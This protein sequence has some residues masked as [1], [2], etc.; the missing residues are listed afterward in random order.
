MQLSEAIRLGAMLK[1]QGFDAWTPGHS[2]ALQAAADA[3]GIGQ[4]DN[5]MYVEA[6]RRWPFL[7]EMQTCPACNGPEDALVTLW[8]LNDQH[9]WTRERIADWVATIEPPVTEPV[10]EALSETRG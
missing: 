6:R 10:A 4:E 1:P 3:V 9:H 5:L 2:C 7:N 8:H